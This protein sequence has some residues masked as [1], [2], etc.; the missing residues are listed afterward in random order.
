MTFPSLTKQ[1]DQT[2]WDWSDNQQ[3]AN[4]IEVGR[5]DLINLSLGEKNSCRHIVGLPLGCSLALIDIVHAIA[6]TAEP[7]IK[8]LGHIFGA[9][10]SDNC[11]FS[12]GL[13]F[14]FMVTPVGLLIS[15]FVCPVVIAIDLLVT[16]FWV[17]FAPDNYKAH[18][19]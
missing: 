9:A 2:N 6:I 14:V 18:H 12:L 8:G 16:P 19:P 7:L 10:F 11:S 5:K 1:W 15:L 4:L 17:A 3:F 13:K